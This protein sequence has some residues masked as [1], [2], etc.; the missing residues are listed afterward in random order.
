[1]NDL[2]FLKIKIVFTILLFLTF[3]NK[4]SAQELSQH[5]WEDRILIIL[6]DS[7]ENEMAKE[8]LQL[9]KKS[10][11]G[12]EERKLIIYE[13]TPEEY[14]L[15]HADTEIISGASDLYEQFNP[16]SNTFKLILIGLDGTVK[17]SYNQPVPPN[18]IFKRIDQMPMRRREIREN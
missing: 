1:M 14:Q 18:N 5:Q 12:L 16:R 13:I 8:Q 17:S 7:F 11:N 2:R 6:T 10:W 9:F 3:M 15:H 4:L